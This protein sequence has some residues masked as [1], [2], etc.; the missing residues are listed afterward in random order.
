MNLSTKQKH[1]HRYREQTYGCQ[2]GG[3]VA[4]GWSGSLGL[5]DTN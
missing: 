5:A 4:K 1:T 2:E 3:C